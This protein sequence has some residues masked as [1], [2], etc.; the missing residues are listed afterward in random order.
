MDEAFEV[1]LT[2][3]DATEFFLVLTGIL[4]SSRL[5]S[6]RPDVTVELNG[7][8]DK[9]HGYGMKM[10]ITQNLVR[11]NGQHRTQSRQ[12]TDIFTL[13]QDHT[14]VWDRKGQPSIVG[15]K[16]IQQAFEG[17]HQ[18]LTQDALPASTDSVSGS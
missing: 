15:L 13:Y 16:S 4:Q 2:T 18:S 1:L 8:G 3:D 11:W 6:H 9:R 7:V 14:L 17:F 12:T 10:A 5:F